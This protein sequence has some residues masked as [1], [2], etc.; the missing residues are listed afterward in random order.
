[1]LVLIAESKTMEDKEMVVD[2]EVYR[3]NRPSGEEMAD[4]VM[5]KLRGMSVPEIAAAIRISGVLASKVVK[6][7]YEFPNKGLG[8]RAIESYTG[9]VFKALDYGTLPEEARSFIDKS[10]GIISS[11]YG[12]LNAGDIIKPYRYD[13]SAK[14]T[15]GSRPACE[16]IKKDVTIRF[17]RTLQEQGEGVVLDLLPGDAAKCVDGKLLKRF[18]KVYKVDFKEVKDGGEFK[19]PHAGK[20][21]MMRGALLREIAIRRIRDVRDLLT[22]ETDLLMPLGTP[23]YPDHIAFCV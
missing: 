7:A 9:V 1:M 11:L 8:L 21:K 17:A 16:L 13:F 3:L 5:G 12:W 19:T 15:P 20:L 14:L 6:M 22:L 10:T 2:K 4:E 23:D 18:A